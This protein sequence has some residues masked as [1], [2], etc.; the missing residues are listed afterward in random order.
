MNAPAPFGRFRRTRG[1][2]A[3]SKAVTPEIRQI[4]A[5]MLAD[6]ERRRELEAATAAVEKARSALA[7]KESYA[8]ERAAL[9]EALARLSEIEGTKWTPGEGASAAVK[10]TKR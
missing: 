2:A 7:S 5:A 10:A 8:P 6:T 9:D 1:Y 3:I 4:R